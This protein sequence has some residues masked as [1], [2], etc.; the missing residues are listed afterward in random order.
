MPTREP[1]LSLSLP[2]YLAYMGL[3]QQDLGEY[4][5]YTRNAI[6][7]YV[8]ED[9]A[10]TFKGLVQMADR[11]GLSLDWLCNRRDGDWWGPAIQELRAWLITQA[12]SVTASTPAERIRATAKLAQEHCEL[13]RVDWF[14]AGVLGMTKEEACSFLAGEH[15]RIS[16]T[17]LARWSEFTRIPDSWFLLGDPAFLVTP[18]AAAQY[19]GVVQLLMARGIQPEEL[20][21][22]VDK[23]ATLL[24]Q[25]R[26]MPS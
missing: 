2:R 13:L 8:T 5:G 22:H 9:R 3:R 24:Q 10:P 4:L 1:T 25:L 17:T 20:Q 6:S 15:D 16:Q 11:T 18:E 14:I 23:V 12:R 21:K 26:L 19:A 7:S